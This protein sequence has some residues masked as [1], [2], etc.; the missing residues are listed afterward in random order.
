M[1]FTVAHS[2]RLDIHLTSRRSTS[3]LKHVVTPSCNYSLVPDTANVFGFLLG[4]RF[5]SFAFSSLPFLFSVYRIG[6]MSH[7]SVY[8]KSVTKYQSNECG[9]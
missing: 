9:Y 3:N 2:T 6:N 8:K 1:T 4:R 7:H 5:P